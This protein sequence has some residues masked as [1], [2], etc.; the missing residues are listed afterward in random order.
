MQISARPHL[1]LGFARQPDHLPGHL[2]QRVVLAGRW[3]VLKGCRFVRTLHV[4][5]WV[6]TVDFDHRSEPKPQLTDGH[7]PEHRVG[8][9]VAET[10]DGPGSYDVDGNVWHL[11]YGNPE[12]DN[13]GW[14]I[15]NAILGWTNNATIGTILSYVFYW[16]VS[17]VW[18]T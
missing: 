10:G 11:T 4:Q 5:H 1:R 7:V 8:G 14:Q 6:S 13:G 17:R 15:F 2:D 3:L 12:T 18:N 16:S 9:D